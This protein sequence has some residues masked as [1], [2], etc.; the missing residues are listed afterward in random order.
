MPTI[1]VRN[2][3]QAALLEM[4]L[5]GQISDG[6]WENARPYDH[7]EVWCRAAVAVD[8]TAV[9]RD[10]HARRCNYNLLAPELLA[11]V[12]GRMMRYARLA[13]Q[14]GLERA[15]EIADLLDMEGRLYEILYLEKLA[16]EERSHS[17]P[18]TYWAGKLKQRRSIDAT[19][20]NYVLENESLYDVVNLR[21]DLRDLKKIFRT[22][23]IGATVRVE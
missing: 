8:A 20:V 5:K 1:T 16:N 6:H 10:F 22:V 11:V 19:R 21:Q 17:T 2:V 3:A 13:T 9:G 15:K 4:E 18:G 7:W 12:G 14:F 23:R